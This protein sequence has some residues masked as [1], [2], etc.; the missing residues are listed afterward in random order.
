MEK[1]I[2]KITGYIWNF[3]PVEID[4]S[5][6]PFEVNDKGTLLTK[7]LYPFFISF[8]FVY[9]MCWSLMKSFN[10]DIEEDSGFVIHIPKKY[11]ELIKDNQ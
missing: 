6:T 4:L 8:T 5:K 3:Y 1:K 11:Q 7:I 9:S 2:T 10:E